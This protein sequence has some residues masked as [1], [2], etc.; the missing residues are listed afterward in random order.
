MTGLRILE[1]QYETVHPSA[2]P[3]RQHVVVRISP[4]AR[5]PRLHAGPINRV[6]PVPRFPG[7]RLRSHWVFKWLTIR[8]SL[9]PSE[10]VPR[11]AGVDPPKRSP[12]LRHQPAHGRRRPACH[13]DPGCVTGPPGRAEA[14]PLREGLKADPPTGVL[15]QGPKPQTLFSCSVERGPTPHRADV[16]PELCCRAMNTVEDPAG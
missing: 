3:C 9:K 10:L 15:L 8:Q 14:S 5:S 2:R 13:R 7:I 16:G 4:L 12:S 6:R 11:R 1:K